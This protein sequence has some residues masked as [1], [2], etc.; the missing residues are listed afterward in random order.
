MVNEPLPTQTRFYSPV[1]AQ[2]AAFFGILGVPYEYRGRSVTLRGGAYTPDFWLPE[3]QA[4]GGHL[5]NVSKRGGS[6][7]GQGDGGRDRA[8]SLYF[9]WRVSR[10]RKVSMMT[11]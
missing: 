2:W 8:A 3:Q 6:G 1:A 5:R 11:I 7:A 4:L 10:A 9:V